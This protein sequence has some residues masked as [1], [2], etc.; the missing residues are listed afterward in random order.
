MT[1]EVIVDGEE[2]ERKPKIELTDAEKEQIEHQRNV[3][4]RLVKDDVAYIYGVLI[5]STYRNYCDA[6]L[7]LRKEVYAITLMK[8]RLEQNKIDVLKGSTEQKFPDGRTKQIFDIE[9]DSFNVEIAIDTGI[10]NMQAL[11]VQLYKYVD[12]PRIDKKIFL[13]KERYQE[14]EEKYRTMLNNIR[15]DV[16]REL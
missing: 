13:T 10:D 15:V 8:K 9:M 7:R 4:E 12:C 6:L 11:F 1:D 14:I 3:A 2:V 5:D 16:R